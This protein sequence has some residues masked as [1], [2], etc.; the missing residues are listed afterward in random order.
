[1]C[2]CVCVCFYGFLMFIILNKIKFK[3]LFIE[4]LIYLYVI[5]LMLMYLN[6]YYMYICVVIIDN[7]YCIVFI[8]ILKFIKIIILK[9][10]NLCIVN[11]VINVDILKI[12]LV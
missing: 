4:K 8:D 11:Y 7:L 1:M 2:D 6:N 9:Y 3:C 10:F 5:D 12:V